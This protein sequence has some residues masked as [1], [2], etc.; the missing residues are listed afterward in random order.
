VIAFLRIRRSE[1]SEYSRDDVCAE[2]NQSQRVDWDAH[3]LKEAEGDW[4]CEFTRKDVESGKIK[5]DHPL[6]CPLNWAIGHGDV[7]LAKLIIEKKIYV[8]SEVWSNAFMRNERAIIKLMLENDY[9]LHDY[10]VEDATAWE[11]PVDTF[12]CNRG[13]GF[14]DD[15]NEVMANYR[16][17][18]DPE[19]CSPTVGFRCAKDI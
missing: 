18:L 6:R 9:D 2:I 15:V 5:D 10:Y 13:G 4:P 7:E 8:S 16:G 19:F 12:R 1:S 14:S 11:D 3:W 17:A